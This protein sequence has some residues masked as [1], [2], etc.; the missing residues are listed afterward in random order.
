MSTA[1][2]TAGSPTRRHL[3]PHF[4]RG[5][6]WAGENVPVIVRGDGC[7]VYDEHGTR[8]LDGL[9]GLFCVNMGHGRE[10][11]ARAGAEQ[12]RRLPYWTNWSAAHPA[13]MGASELIADLAPDGLGS[14]FFVNSGSEAVESAIKL[15]RQFHTNRGEPDRTK[16]VARDMAY[17]GTT[18]GA[19]AVTGI[20]RY[21]APFA[22]VIPGVRHFPNTL[23]EAVPEGGTAGDLPSLRRLEAII[24]EEG[25]DTI[26]AIFAEPVQNSRGALVPPAGYWRRLREICTNHGILLVAD[27]VITA[28]G[29][30]GSWFAS[31]EYGATPDLITF[32]KGATSG[33]APLGGVIIGDDIAETVLSAG[34]GGFLHGAT[35]G[36]HPVATAIA[37]A[38]LTALREEN[39]L[40]HVREYEGRLQAGLDRIR[41][42]H[43]S[44]REWRGAGFF[45][46]LEFM[47][48]R[49]AGRELT[50][51]E[52]AR[53]L[54][55]VMPEALAEIRMITRPDDRGATMLTI[56]PP[57]VADAA[58]L[59]EL[60]GGVDHV[61]AAVDAFLARG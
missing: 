35:W 48:D 22:P 37:T 51:E 45:Y 52:S 43:R 26:A 53:I 50:V 54:R 17:H 34:S 36:G 2:G 12:L 6:V 44:I 7:Y 4:T 47:G 39:V 49:E 56:S 11:I 58:V 10:D 41:D 40:G 27:E 15:A 61:A 9:A 20:D 59:D 19:L 55:Q 38:N 57:L 21:R 29:R 8:F 31:V 14:V 25:A 5:E 16:I 18:L 13:A 24:E 46:A 33:Y 3:F 23:G 28:F 30:V 60:L 32:A 42:E 1:T